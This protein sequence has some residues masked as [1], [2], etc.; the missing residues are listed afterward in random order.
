MIKILEKHIGFWKGENTSPLLGDLTKKV[1]NK[2]PYPI[3]KNK[4]LYETQKIS[5]IDI[6]VSRMIGVKD[7]CNGSFLG[8]LIVPIGYVYP[9]AWME[10]IIECHIFAS[11][12]SCSAKPKF[13]NPA[14]ALKNFSEK[15]C[16]NSGWY[17]K[18]LETMN[19]C[20]S[21]TDA[22]IRQLH[23][24]GIIDMLAA[25]IGEVGLCIATSDHDDFLLQ[26]AEK[27]SKLYI[28][29]YKN[30][31]ALNKKWNGGYVSTW[32][33][34][35]PGTLLD[36]QIDA[37]SLFSQKQYEENFLEYD[38]KIIDQFE[39][40]ITHVHSCGL[41]HIDSLLKLRKLGAI[42]I[43]LDRETNA[44]DIEE[45]IYYSN[46]IQD[47]GKG[48]VLVGELPDCD[49]EMLLSKV[50]TKALAIDRWIEN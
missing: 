47:S 38:E 27:Y 46:K 2:K 34:F 5:E 10:G 23:L 12:Y 26:L 31:M 29:V 22:P 13:D 37:S 9:E 49:L 41:R 14:D 18:A 4:F 30:L 40:S 19:Y 36:Y 16:L 45:I 21:V 42:E 44:F 33:I 20:N 8:E 48:V 11:E 6:E 1:W 35:A 39:Y 17:K 24:R 3:H 7:Q 32:K 25:M 50:E 43:N 28:I 15:D